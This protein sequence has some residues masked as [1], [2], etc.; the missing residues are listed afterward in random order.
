MAECA[1]DLA[2]S[3]LQ[4]KGPSVATKWSLM[5]QPAKDALV[6]KINYDTLKLSSHELDG[7][8]DDENFTARRR[9]EDRLAAHEDNPD[10]YPLGKN[11]YNDLFKR[12]KL[13]LGFL[14]HEI[15]A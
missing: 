1:V 9:L 14:T 6:N 3:T 12:F 10:H 2:F 13:R 5:P 11:F 7:V 8:R 4:G 15:A